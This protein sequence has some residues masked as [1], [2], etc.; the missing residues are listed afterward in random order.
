MTREEIAP[1]CHL[2][3]GS[4]WDLFP[5]LRDGEF[6]HVITDPPYSADIHEGA[7][8]AGDGSAQLITQF[9]A[10]TTDQF[11]L[12]CRESVRVARRWVVMFCDWRH[13]LVAQ[14]LPEFVRFGIWVRPDA[15]PQFT[16]DRPGTGWDAILILH[17]KGKKKWNGGGRHAVW[18]HNCERGPHPTIKPLGLVTE[19]VRQFTDPGD[20]IFDP[21]GGSGTTG[22]AALLMGRTCELVE[23]KAEYCELIRRRM[24]RTFPPPPLLDGKTGQAVLVPA[25]PNPAGFKKYP[26]KPKKS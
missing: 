5:D 26:T 12:L 3:H 19:I 8:T 1:G 25:I 24:S 17:R 13:A 14:S 15:A 4:C 16:G 18:T 10:I 11:L 7:R 23:Q 21:F 22:E 2:N 9:D 20:S 6:G